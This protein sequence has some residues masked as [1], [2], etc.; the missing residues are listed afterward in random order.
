MEKELTSQLRANLTPEEYLRL[1]RAAET[2]SEYLDGEMISMPG[3][4]GA[5]NLIVLNLLVL[6]GNEFFDR[7]FEVYPSEMRVKVRPTGLY[8]YPDIVAVTSGPRFEDQHVDSLLNPILLIEVLSPSTESYDRGRKFSHYRA[9]ESLQEYILVAQAECRV[10]QYARQAD[11]KWLYT[12]STEPNGSI[13][14]TSVACRL[15]LARIYHKVE[16]ENPA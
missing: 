2:K 13:E 16:F 15:P 7:P 9:V 12:E 10:E 11:G 8:S 4:S 5:H 14:L 6:L 1:E 3:A